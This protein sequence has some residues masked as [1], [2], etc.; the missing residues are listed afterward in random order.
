MYTSL[1]FL[2]KK[3]RELLNKALDFVNQR[4][5]RCNDAFF[6]E[7]NC[8]VQFLGNGMYRA[9]YALSDK[10]VVK[11]A[12]N[13]NGIN[14]IRTES[15]L[16]ERTTSDP[17]KK[18]L[19]Q[20]LFVSFDHR[21]EIMERCDKT[22]YQ[23]AGDVPFFVTRQKYR[24]HLRIFEKLFKLED[25]HCANVMVNQDGKYILVDYAW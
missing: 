20:I 22:I 10:Y 6:K 11:I 12:H 25:I 8:G 16:Y 18:R 4:F 5:N 23:K 19:A 15:G 24:E 21:F 13:D 14:D 17:L 2:S 1:D 7:N 3:E 9:C